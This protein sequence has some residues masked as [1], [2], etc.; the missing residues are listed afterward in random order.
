MG[1]LMKLQK[2]HKQNLCY[3]MWMLLRRSSE[4]ALNHEIQSEFL[5]KESLDILLNEVMKFPIQISGKVCDEISFQPVD[6]LSC[7]TSR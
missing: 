1:C 4:G 3:L 6:E 5:I 2:K 7:R